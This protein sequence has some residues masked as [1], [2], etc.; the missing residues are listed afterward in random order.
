M[1]RLERMTDIARGGG[2][3]PSP[4]AAP[5]AAYFIADVL[6]WVPKADIAS[7]EHPIFALRAGD[8][9]V[10][11]YER[12]GIKVVVKA[13]P[14]GRATI[15]D[16]DVWIYAVSQ[17]MEALNRGRADVSRTVRF[18]AHDFF[19]TTQRQTSGEAYRLMGETLARLAGTRVETNVETAGQR[20]RTG[21]GLVDS[22]RVVERDTD[23]RMVAVEVTLPEWLYRSVQS[24]KVLTLSPAYFHIRSPLARRVYELARKHCGY[25]CRWRVSLEVLR[26]KSGSTASSREFRRKMRVLVK[27]NDLPDYRVVLTEQGSVAFYPRATRG[28]VAQIKD[29]I[30]GTLRPEERRGLQPIATTDSVHAAVAGDVLH[31]EFSVIPDPADCRSLTAIAGRRQADGTNVES[32]GFQDARRPEERSGRPPIPTTDGVHAVVD[33]LR[34]PVD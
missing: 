29:L 25:Q 23:G 21:F 26:Q 30:N 11:T 12:G 15:H 6:D 9:C 31:G 28:T 27:R 3:E 10:R 14:D 17:L 20:E 34:L 8:T 5:P 19:T 33:N 1:R 13:G 22:W 32:A 4:T 16:K 7:M 2:Q 24:A 18:T